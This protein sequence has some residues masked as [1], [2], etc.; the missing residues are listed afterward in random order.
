M[1]TSGL[2]KTAVCM[3]LESVKCQGGIQ[4]IAYLFYMCVFVACCCHNNL[5]QIMKKTTHL[6]SHSFYRSEI[7]VG[8]AA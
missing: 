6:L 7:Q 8:L 3:E 5:S 2:V 1:C 4:R